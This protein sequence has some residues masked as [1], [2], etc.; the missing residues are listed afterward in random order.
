MT[1]GERNRMVLRSCRRMYEEALLV[2]Y[3]ENHFVFTNLLGMGIFQKGGL[4]TTGGEFA[5]SSTFHLLPPRPFPSLPKQTAYVPTTIA[6]NII[7]FLH[8]QHPTRET[9]RS[10]ISHSNQHLTA[11]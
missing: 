11:A 1:W 7:C 6:D 3:R 9:P 4:V 10:R 5:L 8:Q 2:L